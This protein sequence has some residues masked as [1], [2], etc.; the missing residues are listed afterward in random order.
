M[1]LIEPPKHQRHQ[2]ENPN[3]IRQNKLS[4]NDKI[5]LKATDAFG[6]MPMF[7]LFIIWALLP[8]IPFLAQYQPMILYVSAGFIQLVA[9]PLIIVG[10]NLQSRHS[11]IRAEEEFKTT[12]SSYKDVEYILNHLDAQDKELIKQSKLI[13]EI[14]AKLKK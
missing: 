12:N 10:Q 8:T 4:L 7:Y 6:S 13:E 9:L 14:L 5:A 1:Q 3:E 11:E 2:P